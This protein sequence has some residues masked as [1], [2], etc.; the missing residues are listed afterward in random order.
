MKKILVSLFMAVLPGLLLVGFYFVKDP[1][2][3][4]YHYNSYFPA[5]GVQYVVLNNDYT[6]TEAFF[7]KA[8][9]QG[10]DSYIFGNSRGLNFHAI[11]WSLNCQS[12]KCFQF[13]VSSETLYGIER[14]I[15]LVD[16]MHLRMR[17]VLLVIDPKVLQNWMY[18]QKFSKHPVYTGES[19][20]GYKLNA[21]RG[22]F[23][24]DFLAKYLRLQILNKVDTPIFSG[25]LNTRR[26]IYIDSTNDVLY[27][28]VDLQIDRDTRAY[29]TKRKSVFSNRPT[30]QVYA[31]QVIYNG[32]LKLLSNI[33]RIFEKHKT[34]VRLVVSPTYD[35]VKIDSND[36]YELCELF[37]KN[38]V[39][40]FSGRNAITESK[41]NYYETTHYRVGVANYIMDSIYRR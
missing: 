21:F 18:E 33:R 17:N 12:T 32:Q 1:F 3:V 31:K 19:S 25:V 41:Y 7:Q 22:F 5:D 2:K 27:P 4:V 13:C 15:N 36:Y 28:D 37:G 24:A 35:Q 29:Y 9:K 39:F 14:K 11:N 38:N 40:D 10:Y 30:T 34:N 8:A 16:S 20:F 23:D 6:S 26:D